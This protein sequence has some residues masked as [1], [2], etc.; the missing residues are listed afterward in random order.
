[1]IT[2]VLFSSSRKTGKDDLTQEEKYQKRKAEQAA[3]AKERRDREPMLLVKFIT[4][5]PKKAFGK[6]SLAQITSFCIQDVLNDLVTVSLWSTSYD[7]CLD[8][9]RPGFDPLLRN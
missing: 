3:R 5:H 6:K 4:N 7:A 1:M 9:E 2:N 8:S